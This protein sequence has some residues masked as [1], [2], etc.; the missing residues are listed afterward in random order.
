MINEKKSNN[1]LEKLQI[2]VEETP[3][4]DFHKESFLSKARDDCMKA[5]FTCKKKNLSNQS[6]EINSKNLINI[7]YGIC[8]K[9]NLTYSQQTVLS[10]FFYDLIS[11]YG[12]EKPTND[13]EVVTREDKM[14]IWF[15]MDIPEYIMDK[16]KKLFNDNYIFNLSPENL[17]NSNVLYAML[18]KE[19]LNNKYTDLNIDDIINLNS[20]TNS[21]ELSYKYLELLN[22]CDKDTR[23][24]IME[25]IEPISSIYSVKNYY[26]NAD[27]I[28]S[29]LF[30]NNIEKVTYHTMSYDDLILK[31]Y[32]EYIQDDKIA[33]DKKTNKYIY[34]DINKYYHIS[35]FIN[36][37]RYICNLDS[38]GLINNIFFV[39][40][41][42]TYFIKN[43]D[44]INQIINSDNKNEILDIL[45]DFKNYV[46]NN[47]PNVNDSRGSKKIYKTTKIWDDDYGDKDYRYDNSK[48]I[49]YETVLDYIEYYG[50]LSFSEE[51]VLKMKSAMD[52]IIP[53]LLEDDYDYIPLLL[54]NNIDYNPYIYHFIQL[55]LS[56]K[57][58]KEEQKVLCKLK[59]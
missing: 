39:K 12:C 45:I 53:T 4:S 57:Q 32:L 11:D 17:I 16:F 49:G 41:F 23:T 18:V 35:T 40:E 1:V 59:K 36:D 5:I 6:I 7:F 50:K 42:E 14:G 34:S 25:Y 9:Y 48:F 46:L 8:N 22:N 31:K 54:N 27:C 52:I 20:Y 37:I 13:K 10:V 51:E 58:S 43:I 24:K 44:L 56:K 19:D 29:Y 28:N 3:D 55:I 15:T 38:I 26:T 33:N 47:I 30:Y 2:A 21:E